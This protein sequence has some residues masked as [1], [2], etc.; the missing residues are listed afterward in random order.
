[1]ARWKAHHPQAIRLQSYEALVTNPQEEVRELISFCG[2]E[3]EPQCVQ[4]E[5]N[6]TPVS[7]ASKVQV[8]EAINARSVGRWKHYA[9]YTES[10][11]QLLG[12]ST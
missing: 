10:L 3:W 9:E 2:L 7:T 11:Q 5:T 6:N 1:M 8:R 4:V 12:I